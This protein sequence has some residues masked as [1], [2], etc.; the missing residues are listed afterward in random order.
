MYPW[1]FS[2]NASNET[3][4]PAGIISGIMT[5]LDFSFVDS[6]VTADTVAHRI[7]NCYIANYL[8]LRHHTAYPT[9]P[10]HGVEDNPSNVHRTKELVFSEF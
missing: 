7:N 2:N 9:R 3:L 4:N 1:R 6:L 8:D 10:S 5:G